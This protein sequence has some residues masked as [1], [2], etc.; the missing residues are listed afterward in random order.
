MLLQKG[1]QQK[2]KFIH[3]KE[4]KTTLMTCKLSMENLKQMRLEEEEKNS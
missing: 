1:T 2:K 4:K 3:R